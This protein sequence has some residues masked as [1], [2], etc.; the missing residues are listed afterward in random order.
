MAENGIGSLV[1]IGAD[2][3]ATTATVKLA[4]LR[5]VDLPEFTRGEADATHSESANAI[6][7]YIP[8][9]GDGGE[10]SVTLEWNAGDATEDLIVA[11]M[12]E[13]D[14]RVIEIRL[15]GLATPVIYRGSGFV[16]SV[17]RVLPITDDS[18][19]TQTVKWRM[20]TLLEEVTS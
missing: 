4:K 17:G 9:W 5:A 16:K 13:T 7:Q 12:A 3:A 6:K 14:D 11:L 8:G 2:T 1:Y 18:V 15:N 10:L 20:N 19:L